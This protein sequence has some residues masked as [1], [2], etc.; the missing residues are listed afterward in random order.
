MCIL[1]LIFTLDTQHWPLASMCHCFKS[2]DCFTFFSLSPL[3]SRA[4]ASEVAAISNEMLE[5]G[6][7]HFLTPKADELRCIL[8]FSLLV[9]VSHSQRQ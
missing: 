5:V 4:D 3:Q 2:C 8:T 1:H 9:Q 6:A 7:L